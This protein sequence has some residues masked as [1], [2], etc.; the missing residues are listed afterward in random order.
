LPLCFGAA[1][2]FSQLQ[3][4]ADKSYVATVQ[5]GVKTSTGDVEGRIVQE[6]AVHVVQAQLEEMSQ[7]FTGQL[8][9]LPPMFSAL[10]K[11]GKALYDYARAGIE[12]DRE[13]RIIQIHELELKFKENNESQDSLEMKVTCSKGTYIRTLA[14]DIGE[15]LGC[16][17]HLTALRRTVTGGIGI[18][19]CL[20]LDALS[21]M[22]DDQRLEQLRPVESLLTNHNLIE[23]DGSNAGRFLSGL[24][25]RGDWPNTA[26][27]KVFGPAL[28]ELPQQRVLLGT[29][30]VQGGELIPGRLLSPI[31]IQQILESES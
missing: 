2:K 14:E 20:S 30:H 10:K 13:P 19:Q 26:Q 9:Q 28:P 21:A 27:A 12:V 29:A 18:E 8:Q 23:L 17:A 16:G 25:R 3:L 6:R 5:L 22:T 31:E 4:D 24:R 11:D 15:T 1:T 7:K